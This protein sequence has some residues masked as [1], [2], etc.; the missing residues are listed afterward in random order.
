MR[1]PSRG[2]SCTFC[3]ILAPHACDSRS[4]TS[5]K[6][7]Q[8]ADYKR[9]PTYLTKWHAHC[10]LQI[11]SSTVRHVG[12]HLPVSFECITSSASFPC[13]WRNVFSVASRQ[14]G[15][16]HS[17][18]ALLSGAGPAAARCRA[19]HPFRH[20]VAR[21]GNQ[22]DFDRLRPDRQ[23]RRLHTRCRTGRA[24]GIRNRWRQCLEFPLGTSREFFQKCRLWPG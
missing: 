3:M 12:S 18:Q 24:T 11:P 8:T 9:L 4:V 13:G 17:E 2:T 16:T 7:S 19:S 14:R 15:Y 22:S 20:G 23:C 21:I 6:F 1:K 10:D 5:F